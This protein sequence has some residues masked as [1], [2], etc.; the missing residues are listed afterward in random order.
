MISPKLLSLQVRPGSVLDQPSSQMD[1]MPTLVEVGK[2]KIP[3]NL[4]LDGVSMAGGS[5]PHV[6]A[7]SL[8]KLIQ[9]QE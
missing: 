3:K 9:D 6:A 7:R 2:G 1:I 8:G 5:L 4:L